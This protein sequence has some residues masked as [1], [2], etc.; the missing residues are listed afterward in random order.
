MDAD[1]YRRCP[2]PTY[3]TLRAHR[4]YDHYISEHAQLQVNVP[5]G[6]ARELTAALAAD[7]QVAAAAAASTARKSQASRG[8]AAGGS[9]RVE[10]LPSSALLFI[11]AQREIFLLMLNDSLKPFT[12]SQPYRNYKAICGAKI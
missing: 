7:A 4:L 2:G 10:L 5:S 6:V 3:R 1:D 8:S 9:D 11:V 12:E